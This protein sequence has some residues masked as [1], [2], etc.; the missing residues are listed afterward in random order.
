[1]SY[2]TTLIAIIAGSFGILDRVDDDELA[3]RGV[4][5]RPIPRPGGPELD[6]N[7]PWP[8]SR[9]DPRLVAAI[10]VA[11]GAG[12]ASRTLGIGGGTALPGLLAARI[13]AGIIPKLAGGLPRGTILVTGT[14]GKTTTT[15]LL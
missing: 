9:V 10:S 7:V 15:R 4:R 12:F 3:P 13:D 1:M 8:A 6:G 11:K 2:L 5:P 14:N